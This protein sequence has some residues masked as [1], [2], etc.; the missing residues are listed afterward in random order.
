M[1]TLCEGRGLPDRLRSWLSGSSTAKRFCQ[2]SLLL[3]AF[4][5]SPVLLAQ[6][7]TAEDQAKLAAV[8]SGL[9]RVQTNYQLA[10]SSAGSGTP[11]SSAARLSKM[12]LD[13]AAVDM[14]QLKQW[15]SELPAGQADVQKL[16]EQFAATEQDIQAL[17]DRIAGKGA[18]PAAAAATQPATPVTPAASTNA[19]APVAT[20]AA[21]PA[22]APATVPAA[23]A[24][25]STKLGYQQVEVLK[26]AQFNL[27]EV[28]GNAA[29]LTE[30]KAELQPVADQLSINHRQV[31]NGMTTLENARRK[32]GFTQDALDK[33]PP[34]GEGVAETAAELAAAN[35]ELDAAQA[36]FAPLSEKLTALINPGNYPELNNDLKRLSELAQMYSNTMILQTNRPQAAA[37][38]K[39]HKAAKDEAARIAQSYMPLMVQQTEEGKRVEGAGNYFL[40]KLSSFEAAAAQEYL[41]LPAQIRSDLADADRL[42]Q[43]AVNEQKPAFFSGGIPQAMDFARDRLALYEVLDSKQGKVLEAEVNAKQADLVKREQSLSQLII[44]QNPL[45][46]DRYSGGDRQKLVDVAIDAWKHQQK[47]FDVLASRIPSDAWARETLWTYSNGSW[48]YV[49][50]S[51]LQVQLIVADA[52]NDNQAVILPINIIKDHQKGDSLIGTPLYSGDEKLQ[53]SA[54]MLKDNVK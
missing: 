19:A 36:Y 46:P 8:D 2:V 1:N 13:S 53:P 26:G 7:L 30:L 22:S 5:A 33:L 34:D 10:L 49:D 29:A 20:P 54:Y 27:R 42:A 25:T 28:Q 37:V 44:Q 32:A 18:A 51:K 17:D 15:L 6:A 21:T 52:K 11:T 40:E 43:Q 48:Y 9:K 39:Q 12:R 4:A 23:A 47:E 3:V 45:P 31:Q 16:A 38:M 24:P 41:A 50:R 35:S 14:P